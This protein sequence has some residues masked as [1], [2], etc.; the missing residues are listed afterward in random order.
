MRINELAHQHA[1]EL[2]ALIDGVILLD[3]VGYGIDSSKEASA[4]FYYPIAIGNPFQSLYYS[5]FLS[6]G[7]IP[8]GTNNISNLTSI[9]WPKKLYL[10]LHWLGNIIGDTERPEIADKK[11][12]SFISEIDSMKKNGFKIIWTV[13]NILPHD[14]ILQDKQ[15]RLRVELIKR[16][17]IIHVMCND[18]QMLADAF[19][20]I[21]KEKIVYVPHPTYQNVYPSQS[22]K[23]ESRFQLNIDQDE[24]VFL[25][26]GS[27]QAYKG[28]HDLV[29]AFNKLETITTKK[30][31]LIIAGKVHNQSNF[32]TIRDEITASKNIILFQNRIENEDV[33]HFF[34]AANVCICPYRI[35]LNSGVAHL[36]HT[37][38]TP[39]IGPDIGGFKELLDK[40]GG[41]V[42][43]QLNHED[44]LDKMKLIMERDFDEIEEEI[45]TVNDCY[46]P[47]EISKQF[48]ISIKTFEERV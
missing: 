45:S 40:G 25:F 11:I 36:S 30:I 7:I 31:K 44:L 37:F 3:S 21:P 34:K 16:C 38:L 43:Q 8:I 13:H 6:N 33:Q 20:S 12:D 5:E 46:K 29:R 42:Y 28:L 15:I 9:R 35:T 17:D 41:D 27:I 14:S 10:H 23:L 19:Y 48:A 1:T 39:V 22:S 2:D 24:F 47:S 4:V 18:T 26:F 32:K